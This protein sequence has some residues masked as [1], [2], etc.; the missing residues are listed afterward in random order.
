MPIGH[1]KSFTKEADNMQPMISPSLMCADATNL[2]PHLRELEALGVRSLHVDVMDGV[3]V[4]NYAFGTDFI[5]QLRKA[6]SIALDIHLMIDKPEEKLSFFDFQKGDMV[7]VHA[8]STAH[9]QRVL[10]RLHDAGAKAAVAINPATP[11]HCLEY[12][13]DDLDGVLLMTVNPGFAGQKMVPATLRKITQLRQ[14]LD[15]RGLRAVPIEVDGNVSFDNAEKM[16]KAGASIFVAGSSSLYH[17]GN[18]I[19]QNCAELKRR[20]AG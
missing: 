13:C 4:P 2:L 10:A 15:E 17:S 9:L 8:E 14:L 7:S 1:R 5:R 19:A 12:V 6:T 3:F 16:A 11:L 18:S 20:V